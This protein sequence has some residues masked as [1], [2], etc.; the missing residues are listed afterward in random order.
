[1]DENDARSGKPRQKTVSS[2][3]TAEALVGSSTDLLHGVTIK[4][5]AGNSGNVYVGDSDVSS[6]N[7]MELEAGDF[8]FL[9][10]GDL[11]DVYVDVATN[12]DGVSFIAT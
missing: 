8:L 10:V 9:S 7:G 3:G 11:A 2:A 4:A 1:M 6:A 12:G 5:L